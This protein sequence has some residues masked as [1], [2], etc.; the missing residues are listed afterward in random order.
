MRRHLARLRQPPEVDHQQVG[1]AWFWPPA[2]VSECARQGHDGHDQSA[3]HPGGHDHQAT[4]YDSDDEEHTCHD[5]H[6]PRC[7]DDDTDN[8]AAVND[9]DDNRA[10]DD[11]HYCDNDDDRAC[12]DDND[13]ACNDDDS[14]DGAGDHDNRSAVTDDPCARSGSGWEHRVRGL[15][16][17]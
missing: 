11:N 3:W 12:N 14:H 5:D 13:R 8:A 16:S 4:D 6:D 10:F 7:H 2:S 9:D 17:G 1:G 15:A